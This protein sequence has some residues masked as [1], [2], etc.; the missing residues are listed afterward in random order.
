MLY[1]NLIFSTALWHSYDDPQ[2]TDELSEIQLGLKPRQPDSKVHV[3]PYFP[4]V[5]KDSIITDK[6][7]VPAWES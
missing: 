6:M 5:G 7:T 3:S 4:R 1:L 2:F